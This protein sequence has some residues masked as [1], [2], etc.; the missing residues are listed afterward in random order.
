MK[1]L[2]N[3]DTKELNLILQD[4]PPYNKNRFPL[5]HCK[6]CGIVFIQP[7]PEPVTDFNLLNNWQS[8][9]NWLIN[10]IRY[11]TVYRWILYFCHRKGKILDFGCGKGEFVYYLRQKGW[12]A[13][14]VDPAIKATAAQVSSYKKFLF[15]SLAH[16]QK[17]NPGAFNAVTLN[18]SL[19]HCNNPLSTLKELHTLLGPEGL[20]FIRVPNLDHILR[21]KRLSSFQLKISSH[22]YFFTTESLTK[23][24]ENSGFTT[25]VIDTRFCITSALTPG[26]SIFPCLDPMDWLYGK[27]AAIRLA[28]GLA[29]GILCFKF[30]PYVLLKS[31]IGQGAIIHAV[32]KKNKL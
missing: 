27:R 22:Q 20:I 19:E 29:L 1:C 4:S 18:F 24:L 21:N 5:Y 26:C 13:Y 7:S 31:Q 15:P 14:G 3:G 16:L 2:C 17:N 28:K 23:L 11:Y 32:A 25:L 8:N 6:K 30:L 12:Q 9:P 10:F